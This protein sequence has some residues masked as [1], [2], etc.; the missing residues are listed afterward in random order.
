VRPCNGREH[1]QLTWG[2]AIAFLAPLTLLATAAGVHASVTIGET[3]HGVYSRDNGVE[4]SAPTTNTDVP[5]LSPVTITTSQ[6]G[7]SATT[8]LDRTQP[9]FTVSF[10]HQVPTVPWSISIVPSSYS[11]AISFGYDYFHVS[12]PTS[13]TLS[14]SYASVGDASFTYFSAFLLDVTTGEYPFYSEQVSQYLSS[15]GNATFVLGQAGGNVR[16][17][18][19]GSLTGTLLPGDEYIWQYSGEIENYE[20]Q[21]PATMAEGNVT[22]AFGS[23]VPEPTSLVVW[24]LI[25]GVGLVGTRFRHRRDAA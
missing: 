11:Y 1:D 2:G 9:F 14:G 18:R 12:A 6:G 3:L 21:A 16:D 4:N 15:A 22:L 20:P 25:V 13:Y 8:V 10:V 5:T 19:L 24:S 23:P 17:T 7:S